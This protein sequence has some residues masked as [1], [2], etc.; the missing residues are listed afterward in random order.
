MFRSVTTGRK[1][2][3]RGQ[4]SSLKQ[5]P[6]EKAAEYIATVKELKRELSR[7]KMDTGDVDLAALS[8]LSP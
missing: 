4:I 6:D 3:L 2:M 8:G 1:L 5:G 7:A